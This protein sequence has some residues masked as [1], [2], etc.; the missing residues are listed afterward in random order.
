MYNA[1][2]H[3]NMS[4]ISNAEH[5]L[6]V[7]G[8]ARRFMVPTVS[9]ERAGDYEY[10]ASIAAQLKDGGYEALLY[11][12]LY[13]IDISDFNVRAVPKTAAL[14]EQ[15]AYS[16]NGIDLLVEAACNEGRAPCAHDRFPNFSDSS[17]YG[18]RR[19]STTSSTITATLS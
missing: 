6:P 18:Q 11:H 4:I 8:T 13:E 12:L 5:F 15:V 1:D 19:G 14:A 3:L 16:R 7:S 2:N 9:S 10:F 17:G